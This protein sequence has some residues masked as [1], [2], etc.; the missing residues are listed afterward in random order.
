M[1]YYI[2]VASGTILNECKIRK[3]LSRKVSIYLLQ[4]SESP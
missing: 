3:A 2:E 4:I 1:E